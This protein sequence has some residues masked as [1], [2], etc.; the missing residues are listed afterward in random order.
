MSVRKKKRDKLKAL[1]VWNN[2]WTLVTSLEAAAWRPHCVLHRRSRWRWRLNARRIQCL[3][4]KQPVTKRLTMAILASSARRR[5]SSSVLGKF[6]IHTAIGRYGWAGNM[7]VES[8]MTWSID[9]WTSN[10]RAQDTAKRSWLMRTLITFPMFRPYEI[11]QLF[12]IF[13]DLE[14]GRNLRNSC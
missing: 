14:D 7:N 2:C 11:D 4:T 1:R 5:T 8:G 9:P 13:A 10:R 3:T 12:L 6:L